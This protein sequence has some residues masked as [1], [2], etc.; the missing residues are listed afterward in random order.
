MLCIFIY[1][2]RRNYWV[3]TD[4]KMYAKLLNAPREWHLV[5]ITLICL[6]CARTV[7]FI[8]QSWLTFSFDSS[9]AQYFTRP[10]ISSFCVVCI[11]KGKLG[12]NT[13]LIMRYTCCDFFIF[14]K[15]CWVLVSW[16]EITWDVCLYFSNLMRIA[17]IHSPVS[18]CTQMSEASRFLQSFNKKEVYI[19]TTESFAE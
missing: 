14:G 11:H 7:C 6:I 13:G 17:F 5:R 9:D 18:I 4:T 8:S 2:G 1:D 19:N 15:H 12:E 10:I 3:H 16:L